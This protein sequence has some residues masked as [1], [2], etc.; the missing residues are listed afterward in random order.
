MD[1]RDDIEFLTDN[2]SV[3]GA[4]EDDVVDFN[5]RQVPR[6]VLW[7]GAVAAA[8]GLVV[9]I[10]AR[11]EPKQPVAPPVDAASAAVSNVPG[12]PSA[13]AGLGQPLSLGRAEVS[14]ALVAGEAFYVLQTGE[15]SLITPIARAAPSYARVKQVGLPMIGEASSSARLILD[16][17]RRR[18]WVVVENAP[19]GEIVEFD[20]RLRLLWHSSLREPIFEAAALNG[21][22]YA[23]TPS[24]VLDVS[25][26]AA[27]PSLI[28][29]LRGQNGSIVADPR[30]GRVLFVGF[31]PSSHVLVLHPDGTVEK[32]PEE[33]SF[34]KA[35]MGVTADGTI[36]AA[37][38]SNQGAELVRLDPDRLAPTAHSPLVNGFGPGAVIVAAGDRSIW[39]RS[40]DTSEPLW[41]VDARTGEGRRRWEV[42]GLVT[43]QRG[44]AYVVTDTIARPLV[45]H[46]CAG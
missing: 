29:A 5:P 2:G 16:A 22:L 43:S 31:S 19:G 1:V 21:H 40:S 35:S 15:V 42:T 25:P 18:L 6:W 23:V 10:A 26:A 36:W 14:D 41:C 4:D 45:L 27:R 30:R 7:S 17:Q 11:G 34:A 3:I 13:S 46:D 20:T 44:A 24:G 37:G 8:A 38:Y 9:L 33:I 12:P 39:V 32:S 28:A